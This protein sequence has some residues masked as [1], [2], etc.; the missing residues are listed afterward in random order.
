MYI[1]IYI[2]VNIIYKYIHMIAARHRVVYLYDMNTEQL[3]DT[4]I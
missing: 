1:Y 2:Y 4:D 3:D